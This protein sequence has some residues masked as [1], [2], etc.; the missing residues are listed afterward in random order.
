MNTAPNFCSNCDEKLDYNDEI[1]KCTKCD[2]DLSL[3]QDKQSSKVVESLPY[4]SP[5]TAALISFIGGIFALPGIGHMDVGKVGRR[6]RNIN[7]WLGSLCF[8]HCPH[9]RVSTCSSNLVLDIL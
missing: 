2:T 8:D 3:R 9:I 1:K 4:K 7:T 6:A 5:G